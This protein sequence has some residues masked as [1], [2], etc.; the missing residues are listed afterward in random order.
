MKRVNGLPKTENKDDF[1]VSTGDID[2]GLPEARFKGDFEF[3]TGGIVNGLPEEE[4]EEES[5]EDSGI[6]TGNSSVPTI[7]KLLFVVSLYFGLFF[8]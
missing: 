3:S 5:Y 1:E 7:D 6:S 8:A 2:N 4:N